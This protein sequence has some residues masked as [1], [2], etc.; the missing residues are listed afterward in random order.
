MFHLNFVFLILMLKKYATIVFALCLTL[1]AIGQDN[2]GVVHASASFGAPGKHYDSTKIVTNHGGVVNE[3]HTAADT[4]RSNVDFILQTIPG[5]VD[6]NL[7]HQ[8]TVK[9]NPGLLFTEQG[10]LLQYNFKNNFGIELGYGINE[11]NSGNN[12]FYTYDGSGYTIRWGLL[13]YLDAWK[14]WY[15]S[16][17]GF[18]RY[19]SHIT[20]VA[21]DAEGF[22]QGIDDE[23]INPLRSNLANVTAGDGN[24]VDVYTAS[25]SVVCFDAVAGY[26]YRHKHFVLDVFAGAGSRTKNIKLHLEGYYVNA[27]GSTDQTEIQYSTVQS[28]SVSYS[29]PDLKLGFTLGYRFY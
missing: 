12:G 13:Q 3:T 21:E 23:V 28:K 5:V 25:A 19:Y 29:Y 1:S 15:F 16:L 20:A 26:Q 8:L 2:D 4:A 18:Y 27:I 9:I 7:R 6:T 10:L 17:Q 11:D 14:H 22:T 24:Q